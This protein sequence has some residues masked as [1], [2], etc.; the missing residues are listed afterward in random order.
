MTTNIRTH[1]R[2]ADRVVRL[3]RPILGIAAVVLCSLL[4]AASAKAR[5][6]L[7]PVDL[8]L[9]TL[10]LFVIAAG[11]G[12]RL[13]VATVLLYLAEGAAGFP[14]FQAT[15]EKGIGLAYMAGPTGGYLVG[16]LAS[17]AIIGWAVDNGWHRSIPKLLTALLAAEIALLVLGC[18]WLAVHVGLAS[19]WQF[20]AVPFLVPDLVKIAL[21]AALIVAAQTRPVPGR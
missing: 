4:L 3:S 8:S 11:L 13:G 12:L 5:V 10:A 9:Q 6:I 19:A 18:G 14:V 15:P 20:G 16:F 2:E 17:A 21:A 7:G 1:T